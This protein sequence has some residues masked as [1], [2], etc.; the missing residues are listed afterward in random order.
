[1]LAKMVLAALLIQVAPGR[2]TAQR[3]IGIRP[4]DRVQVF[5][6]T[7]TADWYHPLTGRVTQIGPTDLLLMTPAGSER[8]IP[9][10]AIVDL[11]RDSTPGH[12][13]PEWEVLSLAAVRPQPLPGTLVRIVSPRFSTSKPV[14]GTIR[15]WNE[16]SV[17]FEPERDAVVVVLSAKDVSSVEWP[18]QIGQRTRTGANLG[19]TIGFA[20]GLLAGATIGTPCRQ[21]SG[22]DPLGLNGLDGLCSAGKVLQVAFGGLGGA[23]VG[24]GLGAVIGHAV[25][26]TRWEPADPSGGR[27]TVGPLISR[28]GIGVTMSVR[29]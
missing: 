23:L 18:V 6:P 27:I 7:L 19:G 12:R 24:A 10:A 8:Q 3:P 2:L 4:G 25:R 5:A 14:R 16:D 9:L 17:A 20:V 15:S 21:G 13:R 29:F 28:R 22:P 26:W 1:M 11:R